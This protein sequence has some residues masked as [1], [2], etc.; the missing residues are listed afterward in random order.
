[1]ISA[2]GISTGKPEHGVVTVMTATELA[3]NLSDVLNRVA[4]GES[5]EVTRSGRSIARIRPVRRTWLPWEEF[6]AVLRSAPS[7]DPEFEDDLRRIREEQN[8]LPERSTP[9]EWD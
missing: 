7:P 6:L 3:R 8:R 5:I 4:D 9:L 2:V 1:M